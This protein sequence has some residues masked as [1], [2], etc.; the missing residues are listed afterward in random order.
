LAWLERRLQHEL[1][2]VI[3]C[4]YV[5]SAAMALLLLSHDPHGAEL[6]KQ[7][8]SG[9]ILWVSWQDLWVHG[10]IYLLILTLIY[11]R[12]GLLNSGWFY[13]LFALSIT[14]AVAL[15]G[16]Y[17]VFASLIMPTLATWV[18][19]AG[20]KRLLAGYGLGLLGYLIGLALS[21][22]LDW[23]SGATVVCSLAV[24]GVLFRLLLPKVK[25]ECVA[26]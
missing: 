15:V 20:V 6:I 8:L 7:T 9:S 22:L 13:P 5:V 4:V 21:A 24:V 23:P 18:I 1:E 12:P 26:G 3:G 11:L 16:V 14:S 25:G 19:G 17:L 10:L 2:A